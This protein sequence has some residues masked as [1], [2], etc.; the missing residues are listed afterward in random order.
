MLRLFLKVKNFAKTVENFLKE[1]K[2]F[3][4][5]IAKKPFGRDISSKP[6]IN[7][8]QSI[9]KSRDSNPKSSISSKSRKSSN[10]S[11]SHSS[12]KSSKSSN[13]SRS[14]EKLLLEK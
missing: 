4:T 1:R 14:S 3:E 7:K 9:S 8:S 12:F 10:S 2:E 5:N 11:K 6:A 13:N